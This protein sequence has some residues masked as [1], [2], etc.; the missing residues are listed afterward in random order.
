MCA[1]R[2]L[3]GSPDAGLTADGHFP[4]NPAD[5]QYVKAGRQVSR[6]RLYGLFDAM[7]NDGVVFQDQPMRLLRV[8]QSLQGAAVTDATGDL[9]QGQITTI[10]GTVQGS[11]VSLDFAGD[12]R[13]LYGIHYVELK[14]RALQLRDENFPPHRRGG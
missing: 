9:V 11:A 14:P 10:S 2:W 5:F 3:V 8:K 4:T 13:A 6:D 12:F 7:R 1:H